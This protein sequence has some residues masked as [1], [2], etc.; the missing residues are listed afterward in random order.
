MPRGF[1][2]EMKKFRSFL[3]KILMGGPAAAGF[4]T[5]CGTEGMPQKGT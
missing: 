5:I 1:L 2:P 4:L 3:I